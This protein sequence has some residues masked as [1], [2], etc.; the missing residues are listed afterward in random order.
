MRGPGHQVVDLY[1]VDRPPYQFTACQVGRALLRGQGSDLVGGDDLVAVA[2][3]RVGSR[4][5]SPYI[6]EVS[7]SRMSAAMAA[8]MSSRC[9]PAA[10]SRQLPNPTTS[11]LTR[12]R[13][14]LRFS[15]SA[16]LA[17][18]GPQPADARL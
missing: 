4:S 6:G 9:R 2:V 7:N 12:S 11:T 16:T 13:A 8:S 10:S 14:R 1:E 3:Q 17:L 15:M 5:T 18:F